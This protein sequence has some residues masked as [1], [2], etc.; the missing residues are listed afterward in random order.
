MEFKSKALLQLIMDKLQLSIMI[1]IV[2]H[3]ILMELVIHVT[4]LFTMILLM[5]KDVSQSIHYAKHGTI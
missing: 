5:L 3:Q 4:T 2:E 1:Q